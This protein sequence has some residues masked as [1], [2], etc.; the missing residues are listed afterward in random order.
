MDGA[1]RQAWY[2]LRASS[3]AARTW[4][5]SMSHRMSKANQKRQAMERVRSAIL[6]NEPAIAANNDAQFTPTHARAISCVTT[7][8]NERKK[9]QS[10]E[11]SVTRRRNVLLPVVALPPVRL[12]SLIAKPSGSCQNDRPTGGCSSTAM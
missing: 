2:S 6:N 8:T 7:A 1:A 12:V 5:T 11:R 3:V 10:W 9:T 4:C